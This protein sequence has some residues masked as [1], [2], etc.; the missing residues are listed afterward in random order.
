MKFITN[1]VLYTDLLNRLLDDV[2]KNVRLTRNSWLTHAFS[3]SFTRWNL[4]FTIFVFYVFAVDENCCSHRY[5]LGIVKRPINAL[6]VFFSINISR[7]STQTYVC[8]CLNFNRH[9][10]SFPSDQQFSS[11]TNSKPTEW[12]TTNRLIYDTVPSHSL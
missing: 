4:S 3:F 9:F 7:Y 12:P 8:T 1:R 10:W 5:M 6:F 2:E 11:L